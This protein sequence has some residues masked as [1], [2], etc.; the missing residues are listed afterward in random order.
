MQPHKLNNVK[1]ELYK[2]EVYKISVTNS[3]G[4]G[5]QK[6]YHE[7]FRGI[8]IEVNLLK[9]VRLDIAVNENIIDAII[10]GTR[11]GMIGDGIIFIRDLPKCTHIR[12]GERGNAAI[13]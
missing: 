6:G 9:K 10:K 1:R 4:C 2:S 13:G 7:S 8:P 5:Q 11:T 12:I 3:L